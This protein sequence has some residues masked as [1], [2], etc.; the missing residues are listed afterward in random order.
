VAETDE[1]LVRNTEGEELTEA[2][3]R[4]GLRQGTVAGTIVLCGS[5]FKTKVSN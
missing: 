2:E 3:I 1:A 4:Q 5:A